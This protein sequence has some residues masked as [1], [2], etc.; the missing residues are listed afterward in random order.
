MNRTTGRLLVE[1]SAGE[2]LDKRSILRLK[3]KRI[4]DAAKRA[5]VIE[6]LEAV[7]RAAESIAP[8]ADRS[9]LEEKLSAVNA[10]LWDAE[11]TVRT[12]ESATDWG[13]RF[14]AAAR[15]IC[16]LNDERSQIKAAINLLTGSRLV[17]E[18]HYQRR[19]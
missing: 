3:R 11:E 9:A 19:E 14:V 2:L 10:L 16:R 4:S 1:V 5:H 17:E 8:S 12:C 18:K 7:E 6:E 15:A 13:E